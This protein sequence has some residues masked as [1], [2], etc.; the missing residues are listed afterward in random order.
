MLVNSAS[1]ATDLSIAAP[2][3]A[4]RGLSNSSRLVSSSAVSK[5]VWRATYRTYVALYEPNYVPVSV[6]ALEAA[7][8]GQRYTI[9]FTSPVTVTLQNCRS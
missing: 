7:G 5:G 4:P 2:N 3:A 1:L 8:A 9:A 6:G